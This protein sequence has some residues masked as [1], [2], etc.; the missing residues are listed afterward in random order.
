MRHDDASCA[1]GDGVGEDLPRVHQAGGQGADGDDA[2]G[3][4]AVGAVKR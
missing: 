4:E 2:F 3:D 1:V